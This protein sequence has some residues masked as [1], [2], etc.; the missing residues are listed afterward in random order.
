M[1][2]IRWAA[3]VLALGLL[4]T[5]LVLTSPD[6]EAPTT[7][8]ESLPEPTTTNPPPMLEEESSITGALPD[9][10]PFLV[11][12][13]PGLPNEWHG[14]SGAVVIDVEGSAQ[15]VGIVRFHTE[16]TGDTGYVDGV[17]RIPA[18]G[19]EVSIEFYE[20]I[21][22]LLGPD[23]VQVITGSIGGGAEEGLPVLELEP[24]FRWATDGELPILMETMYSTFSVRRGCSQFAAACT[25]AGGLQVIWRP[26]EL[27][28]A[29]QW[30]MP[31]VTIETFE[32]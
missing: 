13:T 11:T 15:A 30:R 14:S 6:E 7:T 3:G 22:D 18:G 29:P 27:S 26:S 23:T 5:V 28:G 2:M 12:V 1:R 16:P 17:Y 25:E 31:Q 19:H 8:V 10:T 20:H 32:R 4:V 24:P 21:L 9:G